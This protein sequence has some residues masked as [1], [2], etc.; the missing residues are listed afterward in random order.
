MA[1]AGLRA[2]GQQG[3]AH[4]GLAD[5]RCAGPGEEK[6]AVMAGGAQA[7]AQAQATGRRDG[8][9]RSGRERRRIR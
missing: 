8:G 9:G 6:L 5:R 7:Q 3:P 4:C 2:V 1:A